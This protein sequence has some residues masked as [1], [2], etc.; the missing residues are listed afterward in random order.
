M[1]EY[2]DDGYDEGDEEL[3]H[4]LTCMFCEASFPMEME[5]M[6]ARYGC[7]RCG[8]TTRDEACGR[9]WD[10]AISQF[11]L[12]LPEDQ[13]DPDPSPEY[14]K[15]KRKEKVDNWIWTILKVLKG[16]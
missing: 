8:C 6:L 1:S 4:V 10:A 9:I 14:L 11:K 7:P 12:P 5:A 16:Q 3:V 13:L 15:Q 2:L